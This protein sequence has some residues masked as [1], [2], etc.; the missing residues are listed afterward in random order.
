MAESV[1]AP[2]RALRLARCI[3]GGGEL[4]PAI[5]RIGALSGLH[6]DEFLEEGDALGLGEA[7]DGCALPARAA[8]GWGSTPPRPGPLP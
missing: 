2:D 4:R 7:G 8:P 1:V 6:L 5:E 3:E